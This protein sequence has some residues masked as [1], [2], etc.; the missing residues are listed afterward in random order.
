MKESQ[1]LGTLLPSLPDF[2]PI[3]QA[4]REK[5][6]LPEISPDDDPI[7]EIYLGDEIISFEIFRKDIESLIRQNLS[8]LPPDLLKFYTS[9]KMLME[10]QELI[11]LELLPDDIKNGMQALI[12]FTKVLGNLT[13]QII[14]PMID[15]IV[16]ML[17]TYLLMG[18]SEEVPNDWLSKVSTIS[19]SG[20][21]IVLAMASQ[22][23]NPE[24]IIQHFR[25]EYKKTFGP[26]HP[27]ITKTA[28]STGYY[29]QLKKSHKPWNY[30]VEEYIRLNDF[31]LP[32]DR[33]SRRY[34]DDRRK[35]EQRLKKRMQR[36]EMIL[37][38]LIRDKK[39]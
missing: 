2:I 15:A 7:T 29:V 13:I 26:Y 17:Y 4:I 37:Q 25:E 1:L 32:R 28:V 5:Y 8:F 11:G 3:L 38:G 21:P 9:S 12:K 27:K 31:I 33:T 23:V 6:N 20:E 36:T 18:E 34:I 30:I 16:N 14:D 24:V 39:T 10:V 22:V 19:I 35:I